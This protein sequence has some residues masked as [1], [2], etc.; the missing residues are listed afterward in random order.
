MIRRERVTSKIT[1]STIRQK[2]DRRQSGSSG[3]EGEDPE[4]T[5]PPFWACE[6]DL[7]QPELATEEKEPKQER[8]WSI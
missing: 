5:E 3:W 2:K 7:S 8:I 4:V 6:S 1:N